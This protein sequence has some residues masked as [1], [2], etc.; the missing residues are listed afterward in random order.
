MGTRSSCMPCTPIYRASIQA[1]TG[2]SPF[3]LLYGK[4]P[5]LSIEEA[6]SPTPDW[7]MM[8]MATYKS[9]VAERLASAWELAQAQVHKA[10]CKQ[11]WQHNCH[12]Q[13]PGFKV[14]DR[15]FVYMLAKCLGKAYKFARPFKR[16]Y[17]I[18]TMFDT[19]GRVLIVQFNN[20][21]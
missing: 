5:G 12:N 9:E 16:P 1:S 6:L 14:G 17:R 11:K 19:V 7:D 3:F 8:D 10:Q 18:L 13:N 15:V 21:E 2:E 20:C 4:D